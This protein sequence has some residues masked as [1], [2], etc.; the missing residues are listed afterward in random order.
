MPRPRNGSIFEKNG[1]IYVRVRWTDELKKTRAL[2]RIAKDYAHAETIRQE[3][4]VE[5]N[6][7]MFGRD[8]ENDTR[9]FSDL[10]AFYKEHKLKPVQKIKGR[11][12]S[13][14]ASF[15]TV[16]THVER[17]EE[18]FGKAP[19]V[20]ITDLHILAFRQKWLDKKKP[21][22][23]TYAAASI[24]RMLETMRAMLIIAVK[25][26]WLKVSPFNEA[27]DTIIVRGAEIQRERVL[28]PDEEP[29]LLAACDGE[30]RRTH[31]KPLLL[32]ALDTAMRFGEMK[33]LCWQDIDFQ[34]RVITVVAENSK[35]PVRRIV[36]MSARL[37]TELLA[38]RVHRG[39]CDRAK[40]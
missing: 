17:L 39:E 22:G 30:V 3:L 21:D 14:L 35:V 28:L 31:L 32:M 16:K 24:N 40:L 26:R 1:K 34:S 19:L 9:T 6:R 15:D 36:P 20:N 27:I 2:V 29:R 33:R 37:K 5:S 23:E 12:V 10:V 7:K 13:G 8:Q 25:K 4:L 38:W 11:K 18:E